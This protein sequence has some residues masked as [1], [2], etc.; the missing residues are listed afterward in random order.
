MA[1]R[2]IIV[3]LDT[4]FMAREALMLAARLAASVD[5]DLKGI[6]VEDENLLNLSSLPFA[7]EMSQAGV[8]S[9]IDEREML[10]ALEAQAQIARRILERVAREAHVASV[11][12]IVRGH[13]LAS[14]AARAAATDTLIIR[15]HEASHHDVGR[16]VRAATRDVRADV[17]LAGRGVAVRT[18]LAASPMSLSASTS[19]RAGF[20]VAP[21]RP[22]LAIDEGSTLGEAC[23]TFAEALA[24]RVGTPFRRL[25]ARG[26]GS[27]DI[28]T[29]ARKM[30]AALIV[31]NAHALGDDDDAARLS[32]AAGCPVL[33]LGGERNRFSPPAPDARSG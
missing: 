25:Y 24:Q 33:L 32:A 16:A 3:G 21:E 4:G 22:V 28:A 26:F 5:A 23:V 1:E 14:L 8:T 19:R 2:H 7:S 15:A 31:V 30:S 11:F 18:S 10:R 6:F 9:R 12:D 13:R 29:A 17:L 27:A 20:S